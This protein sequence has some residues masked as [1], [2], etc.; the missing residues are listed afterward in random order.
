MFAVILLAHT[1]ASGDRGCDLQHVDGRSLTVET[2]NRAL[3]TEAPVVFTG[4]TDSW[5]AADIGLGWSNATA[6][7]KRYGSFDLPLRA[8]ADLANRGSAYAAQRVRVDQYQNFTHTR[9]STST[10]DEALF[11]NTQEPL[12]IVMQG[13]YTWPDFLDAVTYDHI[14][15][16]GHSGTGVPFHRHVENWIATFGRKHW[17][18]LPPHEPNP[19]VMSP[20]AYRKSDLAPSTVECEQ[21]S[22]EILFIPSGWWH[23]TCNL[24]WVVGIGG[25]GLQGLAG[26]L[27]AM[28][29]AALSGDLGSMRDAVHGISATE[30]NALLA[31]WHNGLQPLHL[32]AKNGNTDVARW[33]IADHGVPINEAQDKQLWTPLHWATQRGELVCILGSNRLGCWSDQSFPPTLCAIECA[34][35]VAASGWQSIGDGRF[36]VWVVFAGHF[37]MTQYLLKSGADIHAGDSLGFVPVQYACYTGRRDI[38]ELLLEVGGTTRPRGSQACEDLARRQGYEELANWVV[39]YE[40]QTKLHINRKQRKQQRMKRK[41][42]L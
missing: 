2:F 34:S 37:Q 41:S 29:R 15:G 36:G 23:A 19:P 35:D 27:P 4:L 26:P 10:S 25:Q 33:L 21:K 9:A 38:L 40:E 7:A 39:R 31:A 18:L 6:F 13:E 5:A 16:V 12:S 1:S 11:S 3:R 42:E 28:H 22:G 14:V 17:F 8:S 30:S 24:D 20:C 32:A